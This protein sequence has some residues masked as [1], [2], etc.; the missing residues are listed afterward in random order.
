MQRTRH[1]E[2]LLLNVMIAAKP[3][4]VIDNANPDIESR[5]RYI[6]PFKAARFELVGY[7]FQSDLTACL[8]R[9]AQRSGKERVPEVGIKATLKKL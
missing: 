2:A 9:N 1:R 8:A 4:V 6:Q 5:L 7:Y 3:P